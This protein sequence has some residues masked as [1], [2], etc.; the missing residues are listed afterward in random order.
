MTMPEK[1]S[2]LLTLLGLGLCLAMLI[3][4][5]QM[6]VLQR[7]KMRLKKNKRH[8]KSLFRIG[9]D[10]LQNAL[11][12]QDKPKKYKQLELFIDLLSGA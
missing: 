6:E 5:L 2:K 1:I 10:A 7:V 11:F 8:A 4:E 3:G 12:N 9:L